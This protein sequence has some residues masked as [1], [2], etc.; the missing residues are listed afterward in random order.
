MIPF[1]VYLTTL[2]SI[3]HKPCE[4]HV[5]QMKWPNIFEFKLSDIKNKSYTVQ[6]KITLDLAHF[7]AY[8]FVLNFLHGRQKSI[9]NVIFWFIWPYC[10]YMATLLSLMLNFV[11]TS[12]ISKSAIKTPCVIWQQ[13]TTCNLYKVEGCPCSM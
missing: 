2:R 5:I 9:K 4:V 11:C 3:L 7:W 1:Y 10:C 6:H 8:D 13:S 12:K